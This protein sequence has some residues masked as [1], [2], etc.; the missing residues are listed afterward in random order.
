MHN[1]IVMLTRS[2]LNSIESKISKTL[3]DNEINKF[4]LAGEKCQ[5]CIENNPDLLTVLTDHLLKTKKKFR[6]LKTQEIR[7]I[8]TKMNLIRP[9]FNTIWLME[10]LNI[11]KEE[12]ILIM[13]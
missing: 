4:L 6:N 8:F 7:V 5:K 9:A 2:K 12:H 3:M 1:K 11:Q 10:N 13:F